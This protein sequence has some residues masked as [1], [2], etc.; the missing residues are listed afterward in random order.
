MTDLQQKF[1]QLAKQRE[2]VIK[3]LKEIN[4]AIEPVMEELGENTVFQGNDNTVYKIRK[5][6]GQFVKPKN[7]EYIRTRNVD[8]GDPKSGGVFLS[9]KEATE[10][11]F[12]I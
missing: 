9:K 4:E 2:E 12:I 8:L 10:N 3:Q 7:L 11:G 1:L 5:W 6:A